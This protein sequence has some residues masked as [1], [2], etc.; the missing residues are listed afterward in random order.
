MYCPQCGE[1]LYLET[2]QNEIVV[3]GVVTSSKIAE[4]W[5]D[6]F[7]DWLESRGECFGGGVNPYDVEEDDE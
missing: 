3:D 5:N 2:G 6:D 1:S 7:I 4:V